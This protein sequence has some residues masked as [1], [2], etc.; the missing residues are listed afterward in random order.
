MAL[1][2]TKRKGLQIGRQEPRS[3]LSQYKPISQLQAQPQSTWATEFTETAQQAYPLITGGIG[4]PG[5]QAR[6]TPEELFE[7]AIRERNKQKGGSSQWKYWNDLAETIRKEHETVRQGPPPELSQRIVYDE[8]YGIPIAV[9]GDYQGQTYLIRD[10]T[11]QAEQL[12]SLY[13]MTSDPALDFNK[14]MEQRGYSMQDVTESRAWEGL[15]NLIQEIQDP[16]TQERWQQEGIGWAEQLL[17]LGEGGYEREVGG[18]EELLSRGI[19]GQEGLGEERMIQERLA[20]QEVRRLRDDYRMLVESLAS[21]G[22]DTEAMLAADEALRAIGN[23]QLQR[24]AQIA[25]MDWARKEAEYAALDNRYRYMVQIGQMSA[26]EYVQRQRE[27][28]GLQVTL[29]AQQLAQLEQA[30]RQYLIEHSQ[31]LM[32]LK[33]HADLMYNNI[34][35]TMQLDEA[36]LDNMQNYYDMMMAPLTMELQQ[37]AVALE[38]EALDMQERQN[39]WNNT[40]ALIGLG[41]NAIFGGADVAVAAAGA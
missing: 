8:V 20:A 29:Y 6:F 3:V 4:L 2:D 28:A 18:M 37:Q 39:M 40:L 32:A 13:E 12:L 26:T 19:A 1:F 21:Q 38:R 23:V 31:D 30:N 7:E 22:R 33:A 17:G 34:T 15:E 5:L 16:E 10:L 27:H 9:V 36:V 25:E 14:W 11:G 24:Q 35:A 41:V